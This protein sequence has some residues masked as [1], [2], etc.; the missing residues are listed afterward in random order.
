MSRLIAIDTE[1]TGL[2]SKEGDRI[3]EIAMVEI[4]RDPNPR[5]YHQMFN[6]QGRA[7]SREATEVHGITD[8]MLVDKPTFA[9]CIPDMLDFLG[10]D[11][12]GV[13]H[14]A[15]FDLGFL[16]DEWMEAGLI[17]NE[18]PVI[19]TLKEAIKDFPNSRHS[20]DALCN[21]FG[22]DLSVRKKHG[23]LIDTQLLGQLYLAWKGQSGLDLTTV[24]ASSSVVKIE[25]LP[26]LNQLLV[27]VPELEVSASRSDI[28]TRHF[29]GVA[30]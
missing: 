11:A 4:T 17:W 26:D 3:I 2:K 19:D 5:F 8:D 30:L 13:I 1:T 10:D 21:R 20:L 29:G 18:I 15:P 23:A 9:E 22:I 14:N 27:P 24:R 25:A 28:W 12:T 7:I 16:R 6:P